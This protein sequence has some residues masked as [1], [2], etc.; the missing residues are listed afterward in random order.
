M[1]AKL[2][3]T[4]CAPLLILSAF[5]IYSLLQTESYVLEKEKSNVEIQ[6]AEVL[7]Q[8][9]RGQIDTIAYAISD[10]YENSELENIKKSLT[11]EMQ[12]YE[13]TIRKIY[14]SSESNSEAEMSIYQF[15]N[16]HR[17]ND[18]RYFFAYDADTY[19]SKAYGSDTSLIGENGYDKKDANGNYFVR[20]VIN[21]AMKSEI[22]FIEYPFLN[23]TTQQVEDKITAAFYFKPLNLVV[24]SGEYIKTLTQDNLEAAKK[25][26]MTAK[27]G[28]NGY[29]WIQDNNG[30]IIAHPKKDI[31][32]TIVPSTKQIAESIQGKTEAT[33]KI[34][35]E[36]PLT[37][38]SENKIAYTRKIFPE[39]GWTIA[40][41]VYESDIIAVQNSLTEVTKT[42]FEEQVSSV[43]TTAVVLILLSFIIVIWI[44]SA[45]VEGLL[46]LKLRIDTLSTG[47][48]DLTSRLEIT[49]DDELGDISHSVND[50]IIFLQTMMIDISQASKHITTNT[51]QLNEQSSLV[52]QA[53]MTHANETDQ[54]VSA[55]TEMS[56]TSETVAQSVAQ[57]SMNTQ[58]ANDEAILSKSIVN[59]AAN[60]VISLVDEVDSAATNI[61]TMSDN[62]K[63][64]IKV[65]SV[66][67]EIA[68]QTNLLALNAAIEAARAGEQGR[69]F[70]V[71]ADEVR[72]LA[73]RTQA[74]TAEINAILSTLRNDAENAVTAMN[75]TRSSC[76]RTAENTAR[77]TDS[78]DNLTN[79]IIEI[80]DL[81]AQIA[82][83]SE[84]QSSVSE[85]VSRNMNNISQTV[86]ALTKSGQDTVDSTQNLASANAQLDTL[87]N[88]F[89]L[90]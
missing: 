18:G 12:E 87:V 6:L 66:I 54:V 75:V 88:K 78:L 80:N 39:W 40:T 76:Q 47:E 34:A 27:Y 77:V 29:F 14:N 45:I 50:F 20:N 31:I 83:A 90:Q 26:V 9:L 1:K 21:A 46:A 79:F 33:V 68:D 72:S 3:V 36:N 30:K 70:A 85:E 52:N 74:S 51:D 35:Y 58:K 42:I 23:P 24:A 56:S 61:N 25:A 32:G 37:K 17:W 13:N 10:Y 82:T 63:Q 22:G 19:I 16:R 64:I 84:E 55:I 71:V 89:K 8:N 59:E 48:A 57:T 28:E 73:A 53:L 60:S 11:K 15:L 81:S 62:T 5:F 4:L 67:G 41:G 2:V 38:E 7:N 43:S 69:G 44:I 86:Q 65:L 49:S